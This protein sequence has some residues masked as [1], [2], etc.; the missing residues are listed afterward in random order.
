MSIA[1][2]D[3]R[4]YVK[5]LTPLV[6]KYLEQGHSVRAAFI[7]AQADLSDTFASDTIVY[8]ADLN[9]DKEDERSGITD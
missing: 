5:Y 9:K 1:R 8:L 4:T 2:V 3:H 7:L 6:N